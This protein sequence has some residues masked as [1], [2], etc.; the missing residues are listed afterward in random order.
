MPNEAA[1]APPAKGQDFAS[2][3]PPAVAPY[4]AFSR[5]QKWAIVA[6]VSGA[7]FFGPMSVNVYFSAITQVAE[8]VGES[9]EKINLSITVSP[10]AYRLVYLNLREHTQAHCT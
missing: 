9:V 5:T 7:A 1:P 4:S 2:A 10:A 3:Q 6:L 8:T